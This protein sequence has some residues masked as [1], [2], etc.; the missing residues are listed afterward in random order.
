MSR[1][2]WCDVVLEERAVLPI[3]HLIHE[4]LR[5]GFARLCPWIRSLKPNVTS[6]HPP[7]DPSDSIQVGGGGG[8]NETNDIE[9]HT[10]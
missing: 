1:V 5:I 3:R 10:H 6:L 2:I 9:K 7:N 4:I 8:R